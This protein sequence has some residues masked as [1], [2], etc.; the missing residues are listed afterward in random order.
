MDWAHLRTRLSVPLPSLRGLDNI[1]KGGHIGKYFRNKTVVL[2]GNSP[3]RWDSG[4][5]GVNQA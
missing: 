4:L 5:E 1:V 2:R 3:V